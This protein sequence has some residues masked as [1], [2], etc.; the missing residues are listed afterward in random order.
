MLYICINQKINPSVFIVNGRHCLRQ[1]LK[2]ISKIENAQ[3]YSYY[4]IDTVKHCRSDKN[5]L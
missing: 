2:K 4:N 1:Y 3:K 5:H